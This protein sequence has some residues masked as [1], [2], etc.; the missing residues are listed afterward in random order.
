MP[1]ASG[2]PSVQDSGASGGREGRGLGRVSGRVPKGHHCCATWQGAP[3]GLSPPPALQ[4]P[5]GASL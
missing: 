1:E 2:L 4:P 5:M 3:R